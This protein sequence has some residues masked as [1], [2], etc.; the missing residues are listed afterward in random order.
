MIK[1]WPRRDLRRDFARW[2]APLGIRTVSVTEFAVPDSLI[3]AIPEELLAGARLDGQPYVAPAPEQQT[4]RGAAPPPGQEPPPAGDGGD[5]EGGGGQAA[6]EQQA[7][8]AQDPG[9][10]PA[11][12]LTPQPAPTS[13]RTPHP[14][15]RRRATRGKG[16]EGR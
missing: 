12:S 4:M 6:V 1:I 15:S 8:S 5:D 2:A 11:T 9:P 3:P 7:A 13:E 10:E 16:G 14:A